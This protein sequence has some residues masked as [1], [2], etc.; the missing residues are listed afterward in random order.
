[1]GFCVE[2]VPHLNFQ[3]LA[4]QMITRQVLGNLREALLPYILWKMKLVKVGYD[5]TGRMSPTTLERE[6]Q[7]MEISLTVIQHNKDIFT[8]TKKV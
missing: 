6:I 1:M 7:G 5:I 4:T 2:T 8:L 3:Q